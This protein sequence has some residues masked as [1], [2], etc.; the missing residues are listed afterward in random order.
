MKRYELTD[1]QWHL[2]KDLMPK[3]QGAGRP[4][5]DHRRVI[6]GMM[7][8]LHLRIGTCLGIGNPDVAKGYGQ[9]DLKSYG[10]RIT[11]L[12]VGINRKVGTNRKVVFPVA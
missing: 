1:A 2:I 7:W 8:I 4:W 10:I 11:L 9:V 12:T 3:A 6:N 5:S